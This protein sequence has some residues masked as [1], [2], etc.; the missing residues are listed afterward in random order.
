MALPALLF[1]AL[2]P[3][4]QAEAEVN[5]RSDDEQTPHPPGVYVIRLTRDLAI[6][7]T[8]HGTALF[9]LGLFLALNL[10]PSE[11]TGYAPSSPSLLWFV[12]TAASTAGTIALHEAVHGMF[13][14]LFGGRPS[15]GIGVAARFLPYAYAT[16]PGTP[17]GFRQMLV[18]TLAPLALISPVAWLAMWLA[19]STFGIAAV[20]F[21][22][23][24]SGSIGDLW[25]AA[26]IWQ[27]RACRDLTMIDARDSMTIHTADPQGAAIAARFDPDARDRWVTRLLPRSV[28]ATS[29]LLTMAIPLGF[30]LS[31]VTA[32]KVTI[33]PALFPLAVY[34]VTY[35]EGFVIDL[36]MPAVL[37]AGV[38][39]GVLSLPIRCRSRRTPVDA[40]GVPRP[41]FL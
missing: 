40:S 30:A 27:F 29:A 31:M 14:W 10:Y 2:E 38:L 20:A 6:H 16:A 3:D 39:L 15:F 12:V 17:F 36:S 21:I 23:N 8:I 9:Y 5:V 18:I 19:P 32:G 33:G 26:R 34:D 13:M 41:A 11:A 28:L 7:L 35:G 4:A 25:M 22:V 37:L 24:V 1:A